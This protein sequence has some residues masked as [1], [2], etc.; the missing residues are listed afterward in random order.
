MRQGVLSLPKSFAKPLIAVFCLVAFQGASAQVALRAPNPG[1]DASPTPTPP[2]YHSP[3]ELKKLPLEQLV[4]VEITS[5]ARRPEPLWQSASA[6]DVI[7]A[8]DIRRAGATNIP[9]ALRLAPEMEVAQIDGH[10]WAISTRGFSNSISNKLQ[11]LMDG[12]TLY[13]PLFSGVFWDVQQTFLPDIDQIEI[14]RGPGATLWGANAVNGVINIRTKP[15]DETQGFLLWGGGGNEESGF[16][17]VRYGGML[18][19]DTAYRFYVMHESR[20][21]LDLA[22]G[23]DAQD[24]Y[25]ITQGGFRVD[26]KMTRDD[27]ITLQGDAYAG[28]FGQLDAGDIDVD[29]QNV[30][31]R[32]T[33]DLGDDSSLMLQAYFDRTHRFIPN[34]FEESRETYDLEFQHQFRWGEHEI[35]YGANYRASHDDIGNIGTVLA[36]FP[37]EETEHLVSGYAQDEWHV[38]PEVF[39][40]VAGSKFEW[41]SF[42][43]FEV[44]PT[45]RFVWTP[46]KDQTMWGAISRAVRTPTRIDQ[47]VVF[48]FN[49]AP[50]LTG[51]EK[52]DSEVLVAYE[53]GYRWKLSDRLSLDLA[54]YYNHYDNLR[55]VEPQPD[56][57]FI[58]D[59]LLEAQSY[60]GTISAKWRLSDWWQ[61]DGGLSLLHLQIDRG[62]SHDQNR[63]QGEAN[64]PSASFIIHS[65]IDL[66]RNVQFDSYL[67]Y[68]DDLPHPPVPSYLELDLRLGWSPCKNLEFSVVGRNLLDNAHPE[69]AS[70]PLTHEVQRSVYGIVQ[71]SF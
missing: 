29:G 65:A 63:G 40:L 50:I 35:V 52:F 70:T 7:T 45:G 41:N 23:G 57:T 53:L 8:D 31:G 66:P 48:F 39:S 54:G 15:A 49:G 44:Q 26:S 11:V 5:A 20:D 9:D 42:S 17:G 59:N 69:F 33:R 4:D 27:A 36:F 34:V 18:N 38:V 28:N 12:R 21:S 3:T 19:P 43:G 61:I 6:V 2:G 30:L 32:W 14:I 51:S 71:W 55:S 67:R 60:G 1:T 24:D 62:S 58:I 56:N 10:D 37:A 22:N 16:G 46:A 64:D 68:V 13:T 25:H 47:D